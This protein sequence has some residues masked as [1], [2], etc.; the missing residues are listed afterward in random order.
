[1]RIRVNTYFDITETGVNRA[2]KGQRLPTK[3]NGNHIQTADQWNLMRKQQ[4]NFETVI[5]VLSMRGTPVEISVPVL[6]NGTW[7][8]CF[9]IDNVAVYGY[10]MDLLKQE[11]VGVPMTVGLTEKVELDSYLTNKNIWVETDV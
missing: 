4:T 10:N 6:H 1:M 3:I 11:L 9:S 2:Y 7:S 8:F 5:Q